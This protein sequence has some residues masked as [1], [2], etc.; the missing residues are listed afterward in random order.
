MIACG[1]ALGGCGGSRCG[2]DVSGVSMR[3]A[4]LSTALA[5]PLPESPPRFP[6]SPAPLPVESVWRGRGGRWMACV[7]RRHVACATVRPRAVSGCRTDIRGGCSFV[8]SVPGLTSTHPRAG[9]HMSQYDDAG[10]DVG[11]DLDQAVGLQHAELVADLQDKP[12][13]QECLISGPFGT[14]DNPVK[15]ES[16]LGYRIVGCTGAEPPAPAHR[17]RRTAD[18]ASA[19]SRSAHRSRRLWL[20]DWRARR[21]RG[22]EVGTRRSEADREGSLARVR[23]EQG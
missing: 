2:L 11:D 23:R 6:L 13:F 14:V 18:R 4:S 12:F 20:S 10:F 8:R 22:S 5:P 9:K 21:R 1:V 15:V 3:C 16:T 17:T 7:L 19:P